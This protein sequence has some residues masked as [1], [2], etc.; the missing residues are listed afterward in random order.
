MLGAIVPNSGDAIEVDASLEATPSV[1]Y[2][3]VV[4]PDGADAVARLMADGRALEFVKDQYRHAKP[5]LALGIGRKLLEACGIP[6]T[7]PAGEPDPG[8]LVAGATDDVGDAFVN[9]I[10]KHRHFARETDP[11]RI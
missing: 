4:L 3:A 2:D 6:S 11:P 8:L 7:L 5:I 1:L 10:A 9:A